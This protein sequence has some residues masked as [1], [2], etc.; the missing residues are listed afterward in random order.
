MSKIFVAGIDTDIGKTY[1]TG[2]LAKYFM[3]KNKSVITLK[4]AQTGCVGISEDILKH[5]EIMNILLCDYDKDGTTC[6][7]V[8]KFPASPHLAAEME[9]QSIDPA[10]I[11]NSIDI[12]ANNFNKLIIEGVGGLLVPLNDMQTSIDFIEKEKLA[13]ILVSSPKLGSI[14]HTLLSIEAL[15]NRNITLLGIIYNCFGDFD[16]QI[17]NDSIKV[18]KSFLNKNDYPDNII[19]INDV[20]SYT[21]SDI[22]SLFDELFL[23]H[24]SLKN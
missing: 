18:F 9:N 19:E 23:E 2:L 6:P 14:N 11:S 4:I 24:L 16:N 20:S 10:K 13:V 3:L 21:D 5:R 8:F 1:A 15:K 12:L 17:K 22:A 7:Y